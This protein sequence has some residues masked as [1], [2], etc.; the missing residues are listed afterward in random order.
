MP[1][2]ERRTENRARA[3]AL[4]TRLFTQHLYGIKSTQPTGHVELSENEMKERERKTR[5]IARKEMT[6]KHFF[7]ERYIVILEECDFENSRRPAMKHG[8]R[9]RSEEAKKK[10]EKS[11]KFTIFQRHRASINGQ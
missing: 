4:E 7:F 2:S 1:E 9:P 8:K 3:E 11:E 10:L 6:M 5:E